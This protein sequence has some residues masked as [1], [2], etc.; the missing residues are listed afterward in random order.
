MADPQVEKN[1][2]INV[3]LGAAVHGHILEEGLI[4]GHQNQPIAQKTRLGW[5][6]SGG[7]SQITCQTPIFTIQ[8]S[9]SQLSA[10][11]VKFWET[12]EVP[13]KKYLTKEEQLAERIY[14]ETTKRCDDGRLMVKL[15]FKNKDVPKLGQSFEIAKRRY[16]FMRKRFTTKPEFQHMYDQCIQQYLDLGHMELTN[17]DQW[18]HNYLPHHPVIK[19][20]SSTTKIRPVFDASCKTCNGNS[21]N[22]QLL[23]GPTI[24]SDL[25][26]LLTR[27]R[28]GRI[29]ISGDIEQMYRQVWIFPEDRDYQRILWCP[30]NTTVTHRFSQFDHYSKLLRTFV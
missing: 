30:P 17:S 12:E 10:C 29:A 28:K 23:V 2:R 6:I 9:D 11:L 22:S 25:F 4:K 1:S 5:I 19:E 14:V 13:T 24:Q 15:P 16:N 27:W 8:T 3:L 18:P 26:S 20:S 7:G 21:L